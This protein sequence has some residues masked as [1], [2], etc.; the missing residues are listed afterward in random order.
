M[1]TMLYYSND[2]S[3]TW[4]SVFLQDRL[5]ECSLA[6]LH[7]YTSIMMN[8]RTETKARAQ[9][10]WDINH[11]R[12][13]P[14]PGGVI[15][16]PGLT[17]AKCEGS[18]VS[19][20]V[21]DPHGGILYLSNDDTVQGRSHLTVRRSKDSGATWDDG[22]VV[23]PYAS[24]YSTLVV[25]SE[26]GPVGPL[27]GLLFEYNDTMATLDSGGNDQE[28]VFT[29]FLVD[30]ALAEAEGISTTPL[31]SGKAKGADHRKRGRLE[32]GK[33]AGKENMRADHQN[34]AP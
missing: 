33:I 5:G 30:Q 4:S 34:G 1:P 28:I 9:V 26:S 15:L 20:N 3:T 11:G 25:M 14:K 31:N 10:M 19:V 7:N 13:V 2:R 17:D 29:S 22:F 23:W 24:G 32:D 27:L 16:P 18:I 8:C 6:F 12:G 21:K